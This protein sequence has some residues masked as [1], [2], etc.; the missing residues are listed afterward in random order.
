MR[1]C[2][3][4]VSVGLAA[5]ATALVAAKPAR[6][7][8]ALTTSLTPYPLYPTRVV[9]NN[10][11]GFTTRPA[12]LNPYGL[13][14]ADC[15]ADMILQFSLTISGWVSAP[16]SRPP[17]R[18]NRTSRTRSNRQAATSGVNGALLP[19]GVGR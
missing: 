18:W 15:A 12:N 3:R 4:F 16:Q 2:T 19:A 5:I 13:N 14:Y 6:A 10:N 9:G 1:G 11:M 17:C 8:T 7:Q